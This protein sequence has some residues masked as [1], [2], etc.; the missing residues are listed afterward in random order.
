MC[1]IPRTVLTWQ[2]IYADSCFNSF[3]A[4]ICS[5]CQKICPGDHEETATVYDEILLK[6]RVSFHL[7]ITTN[8]PAAPTI[9]FNFSKTGK[10]KTQA[11]FPQS[12]FHF[13]SSP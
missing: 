4:L 12:N 1:Q 5:F 11:S 6:T 13:N 10:K 3:P 2:V 7:Q 9:N 8:D